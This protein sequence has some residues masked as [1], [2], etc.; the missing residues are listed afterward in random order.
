MSKQSVISARVDTE[1]LALVDKL[2]A[3]QGRSRAWFVNKAVLDYVEQESAMLAFLQEGEDA[4]T[5]GDYYTQ[6][7]MELWLAERQASRA[8]QRRAAG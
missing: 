2:A 4:I 8:R 3:A 6:E 7:E 1:T 5:N